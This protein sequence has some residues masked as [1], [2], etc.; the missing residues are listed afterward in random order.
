MSKLSFYMITTSLFFPS[1]SEMP[2]TPRP[3][4]TTNIEIGSH[5]RRA[6]G[7]VIQNVAT[8]T[9]VMSTSLQSQVFE[10]RL[11]DICMVFDF[12]YL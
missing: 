3:E 2:L 4:R 8:T 6:V 11:S 9:E 7:E 1:Y 5:R 12:V 10:N